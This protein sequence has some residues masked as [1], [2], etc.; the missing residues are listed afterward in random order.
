MSTDVRAY[1]ML[2]HAGKSWQISVHRTLEELSAHWALRDD[3]ETTLGILHVGFGRPPT[4]HFDPFVS[5][6]SGKLLL[7]ASAKYSLPVDFKSSSTPIGNVEGL[8]IYL[9][10]RGWGYLIEGDDA[11]VFEPTKAEP[12]FQDWVAQFVARHPTSRSVLSSLSIFDDATY[13]LNEGEL[14]F[15]LRRALGQKR[16]ESLF[17]DEWN[18]PCAFAKASPPWLRSRSF[19]SMDL[20]VRARNGLVNADIQTVED[21]AYLSTAQLREL[22]GF[23]T[24]SIEDVLTALE[25]ALE[26]GPHTNDIK[27]QV[28]SNVELLQAI[29]E[30]L[31]QF[32]E[33]DRDIIRRRMGLDYPAQTLQEIAD[34]YS[35]TRERVRQIEN[36]SAAKL[37]RLEYW[38]DLLIKKISGLLKD[39]RFPLPVVAIE[40][41][42]P[43]FTD[44][45]KFP[46]A[47]AYVLENLCDEAAHVLTVDATEYLAFLDQSGWEDMLRSAQK[48]LAGAVDQHW[49]EDQARSFVWSLLP[50]NVGEFRELLWQKASAICHF[51]V[52]A[53][54]VSV[55]SSYGKS[56]D[57]IVA[58]ILDESPN[59]IHFSQIAEL[60]SKRAGKPFEVRKAHIAASS[61]GLLMGR[62]IFGR[63][64]HLPI[65]QNEMCDLANEAEEIVF[66]GHP[67]RQWHTSEI[68]SSVV[69]RGSHFGGVVDKFVLDISLE[70][71]AVLIKLG[72]MI[73]V[74][75]NETTA[76]ASARIEIRQAILSMVRDA[77][78]PLKAAEIHERISSI[79]G[80]NDHFQII[81][82]DPL[83]R[84]GPGLWGLNDRDVSIKRADQPTF[85]NALVEILKEWGRGIHLTEL[86]SLLAN[87]KG[88]SANAIFSIACLDP[89]LRVSASQYIFLDEWGGPR[90]ES[91]SEAI[92]SILE[93]ASGPLQFDNVAMLV[94]QR[95]GR[96]IERTAVSTGLRLADAI[97]DPVT[98]CWRNADK[99]DSDWPDLEDCT[100]VAMASK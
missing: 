68:L 45:G 40:A 76:F 1:L 20:S 43:W 39:R 10:T 12:V 69:E 6:F 26:E 97:F 54:G 84:V 65:T 81:P 75:K 94:S 96:D 29:R 28:A 48:I 74:A 34:I 62:G 23:G 66:E 80:L 2:G 22:R 31:M 79:R 77:G 88:A 42:D 18:D 83:I 52:R 61:V 56:A 95:V 5:L 27:M 55:L 33:R 3:P 17:R 58:A 85:Q 72:R 47:L 51:A 8:P 89:R 41:V 99:N 82:F 49:T 70:R 24:K 67:G 38:D 32:C 64:R 7:T 90:R 59:P 53:D 44:V 35:L 57:N 46:H 19:H 30:S 4:R 98:E 21:L 36:R 50:E 11:P 9:A 37:K 87:V 71:S 14:E 16:F 100:P 91:L 25:L 63:D 92:S 78:R 13:L 93:S 15:D 86:K 60:A 73:W